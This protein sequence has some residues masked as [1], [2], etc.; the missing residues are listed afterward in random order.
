[1]KENEIKPDGTF[2]E[3]T[4]PC[5]ECGAVGLVRYKRV[6]QHIG[7]YCIFCN[8]LWLGWVKQWTD[9]D[10]DKRIKERD[11]YT[12][13][14]C[15]RILQGREAHAHHKIPKWFMPE[16]QYELDNGICL[17]TVCHKQIHGKGGT[18][19]EREEQL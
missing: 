1:M 17:C 9:K 12:C 13:Q 7:A 18:I 15:G 14:R 19:R 16:L 6:N 5:P 11:F 10:W 3:W 4:K 2:E 8:D